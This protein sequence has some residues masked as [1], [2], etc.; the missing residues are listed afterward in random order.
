MHT[1][2]NVFGDYRCDEAHLTIAL[3]ITIM[4][5]GNVVGFLG[6]TLV[7]DLMGRKMLLVV[8]LFLVV[9][10]LM[11][12]IMCQTLT[13][14]GI[15]LFITTC[16]IQNAFNVCFYFIAETMSEDY[17]EKFSVAI[18]LFYGLGV[19]MNVLWYWWIADWQVIF[20]ASYFAPLVVVIGG[21]IFFIRDTPMCLVTRYPVD[22]ALR[23]F[24]FIAKKNGKTNFNLSEK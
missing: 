22:W 3:I 11:L 23:D 2:S 17:R 1:L 21:A 10:G 8:N 9:V 18:Q 5:V 24:T 13:M 7:G 20:V 19:L 12:T 15:G 16:G 4:Y 6:L 14:A